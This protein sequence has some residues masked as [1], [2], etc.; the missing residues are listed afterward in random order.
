MRCV[1]HYIYMVDL[2]LC[3]FIQNLFAAQDTLESDVSQLTRELEHSEN[4]NYLLQYRLFF[5]QKIQD[6]LTLD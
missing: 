5:M 1:I 2:C 3:T 4:G 6:P